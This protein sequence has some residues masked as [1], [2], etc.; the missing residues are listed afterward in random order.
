MKTYSREQVQK[1]I[2]QLVPPSGRRIPATNKTS[3]VSG[4][5]LNDRYPQAVLQEGFTPIPNALLNNYQSL[6][7]TNNEALFIIHLMFY[8]RDVRNPYPSIPRIALKMGV[9]PHQARVYARNLEDKK[10]IV[11]INRSGKSNEFDLSPLFN[12]IEESK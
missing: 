9:T 12:K 3:E 6:G 11:R 4:H 10:L 5:K 2:R 1:D 7:M 8:K